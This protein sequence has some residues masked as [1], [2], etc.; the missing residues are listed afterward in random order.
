MHFPPPKVRCVGIQ[1]KQQNSATGLAC[2]AVF[3]GFKKI[4]QQKNK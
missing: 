4:L 2:R 1:C 3:L